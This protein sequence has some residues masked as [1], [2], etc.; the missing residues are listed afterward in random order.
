MAADQGISIAHEARD[1]P[2]SLPRIEVQNGKETTQVLTHDGDTRTQFEMHITLLT[3]GAM[4]RMRLR[5]IGE[6]LQAAFPIHTFFERAGHAPHSG[7]GS[8]ARRRRTAGAL[9]LEIDFLG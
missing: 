2:L 3:P 7:R 5:E 4:A 8:P 1:L 6:A 9:T